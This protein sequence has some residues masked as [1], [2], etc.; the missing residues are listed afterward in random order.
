[1]AEVI[2]AL[3]LSPLKRV[4]VV[5][6]ERRVK[7]IISDVDVLSQVQEA[8]RPGL[9]GTLAGWARGKPG[10]LPTAALQRSRGRERMAADMMNRDVVT[11]TETTPVQATIER[12]MT[13][14]RK[15][16]PVVDAQ[17]HLVGMVG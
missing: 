8:A 4:V 14:R 7:G 10:R 6:T 2:D 16:L 15:I 5:D 3:S 12:M 9:L 1:M 11:V 17:E 13:T